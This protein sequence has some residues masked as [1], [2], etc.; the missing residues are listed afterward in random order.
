[1]E[2][3]RSAGEFGLPDGPSL[4]AAEKL[5]CVGVVLITANVGHRQRHG[6]PVADEVCCA[7]AVAGHR[8]VL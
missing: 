1:M 8:E 3:L 4:S 5:N 2:R 6:F 7:V